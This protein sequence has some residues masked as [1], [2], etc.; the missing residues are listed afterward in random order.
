M[1]KEILQR[2]RR[3][4]IDCWS[5]CTNV[6]KSREYNA[7]VN[8]LIRS[9]SSVG[10]NYRA[11][12]RAKSTADFINKLKIVEE[13]ADESL[14]WLEIFQEISKGFEKELKSLQNEGEQL[15]AITVASINTARRNQ[16]K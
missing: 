13:E 12:Q 10:A 2:T 6:P 5:F 15:L 7:Y 14:Y 8:Q 3:F 16:K 4:A 11:A 1:K 9:S